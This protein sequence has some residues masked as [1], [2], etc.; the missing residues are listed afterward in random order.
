MNEFCLKAI[1]HYVIK[2]VIIQLLS[3]EVGQRKYIVINLASKSCEMKICEATACRNRRYFNNKLEFVQGSFFQLNI[4][5]FPTTVNE[6]CSWISMFSIVYSLF[7]QVNFWDFKDLNVL[8]QGD[9]IYKISETN[10][11]LNAD[12][13]PRPVNVFGVLVKLD[14]TQNMFGMLFGDQKINLTW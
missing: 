11:F 2:F 8:V 3:C 1:D 12:E 13:I 5:L 7:K 6:Q 10:S 9:Q 4:L 14:F